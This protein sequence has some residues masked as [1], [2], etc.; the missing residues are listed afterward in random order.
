MPISK[1]EKEE[2][3]QLLKEKMGSAQ[4]VILAD[5][6]GINVDEITKLRRKMRDSGN[7]FRIAKNTIIKLAAK[8]L[9]MEGLDAHLLGSTALAIGYTDP[10]SPAKVL[11]DFIKEFKKIEV[12]AAVLDGQLIE[13]EQV[14]ALANL[15]SREVLL[16][17][18]LGGMQSPMYG[19]AGVLQGLL[20]NFVYA[21]EAVRE[22]KADQAAG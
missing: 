7:E 5:Y 15:P 3:L 19:F 22:K 6:K 2:L 18:V 8:E 12:K 21:L 16:G 17:K 9:N 4:I 11:Y 20:R 10:V 14:K 13:A 1:Q